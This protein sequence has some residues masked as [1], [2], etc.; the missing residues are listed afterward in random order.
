MIRS[1]TDRLFERFRCTGDPRAL[2]GVFDRT[3]PELWR[4]AAHLCRDRHEA[5]DLVQGTFLTAIEDKDS[6]DPARPVLPWLLGILANRA[7]ETRRRLAR[8]IDPA[9]LTPPAQPDPADAAGRAELGDAMREALARV[10]SPYRETLEQHLVAGMAPHEIAA[11]QGLAQGTVRM[12]VHRGL[13]HLR[14]H[15]PRGFVTAGAVAL[16]V[17]PESLATMREVVLAKVPGGAAAAVA[18]GSGHALL[19]VIGA[20][21]MNKM[22]LTLAASAAVALAAW[23]WW[24]SPDGAAGVRGPDR[25]DPPVAVADT[26]TAAPDSVGA[27][28]GVGAAG[29]RTEV[30][31]A[32]ARATGRLRVVVRNAGTGAAVVGATVYAQTRWFQSGRTDREGVVTLDLA[33]GTARVQLPQLTAGAVSEADVVAGSTSELVVDLPPRIRVDATVIDPDGRPVPAARIL[34]RTSTDPGLLIERELGRTAVDGRWRGSFVEDRLSFRAVAPGWAAT[35]MVEL[36]PRDVVESVELRITERAAT[37]AGVVRSVDGLAVADAGV[38]IQSASPMAPSEPPIV[39]EV[40]D[41]GTFEVAHVPPGPCTVFGWRTLDDGQKR[42]VRAEAVAVAGGRTGVELRF[43]R[44]AGVFGALRRADGA[45]VADASISAIPARSELWFELVAEVGGFATTGE[46]GSFSIEGLMPGTYRLQA[47]DAQSVVT[48][49]V[50]LGED[51]V[52]RWDPSFAAEATLD[53][54]VVGADG[55]PKTGW[56]LKVAPE[57]GVV[58]YATTDDTGSAR[59]EGTA[60]GVYRVT[61]TAPGAPFASLT[62][63][64]VAAGSSVV[65]TVSADG[66]PDARLHGALRPNA[67]IAIP[68]L[69]VRLIRRGTSERHEI[70]VD[71]AD[72]SFAVDALV[73]ATY[74]LVV[75]RGRAALAVRPDVVVQSGQDVDLGAIDVGE[76]GRVVFDIVRTDGAR[77]VD[78]FIGGRIPGQD[79]PFAH[80]PQQPVREGVEVRD[81]PPITFDALVWGADIAPV[82]TSVTSRVGERQILPVVAEPAVTTTVRFER[83]DGGTLGGTVTVHSADGTVL[84]AERLRATES[85]PW[86]RGLVPG[87]YRIELRARDGATGTAELTVGTT[88]GIPVVVPLGR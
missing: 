38:A 3:A 27:A 59:F 79:M 83:E 14:R 78:P 82:F 37:I 2:A 4:V 18:A 16:R 62:R 53:V 63:P 57:E 24:P 10:P 84:V 45:P 11:E 54:R 13:D 49:A 86:V 31:G 20:L 73:P 72:G 60:D 88:P 12:R 67:G 80:M 42:F 30:P 46:D 26:G 76:P 44:G 22:F 33:P 48:H 66:E 47:R 39:A 8:A 29:A 65:L 74:E 35:A 43:V 1:R 34:G 87:R 40:G 5:E 81:L 56:S 19:T 23:L 15:L 69:T 77:P 17:P 71:P 36:R 51:E 32:V 52:V 25:T 75:E 58:Q 64:D 21:A 85:S 28:D 41:D 70:T 50:E 55:R 7:R 61:V 9:R 6:W 68:D